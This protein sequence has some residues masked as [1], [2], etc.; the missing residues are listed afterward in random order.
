MPDPIFRFLPLGAIIQNF[1]VNETNIVQGFSKQE[2][3]EAHNTPFYGE[4][5][6]RFANR[7]AGAKIDNLNGETVLLSKND[8]ENTLHGGHVGWGKKLWVGPKPVPARKIPGTRDM[9]DAESV[10]FTLKDFGVNEGFPGTLDVSVV[11]TTGTQET[12]DGKEVRVLGIE[13]EAVLADDEDV[14]E[15]VVNITNHSYVLLAHST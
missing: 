11:Y 4:T 15:T 7:I 10:E 6:G 2:H 14:Q 3:Y 8:G 13:C 12:E 5:I 1:Y 9:I